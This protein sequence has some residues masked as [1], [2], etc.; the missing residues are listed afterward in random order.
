MWLNSIYK[1]G[2]RKNGKKDL[3]GKEGANFM[4]AGRTSI[5]LFMI[6]REY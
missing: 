2:Q 6:G 3:E 5:W 1:F 4:V